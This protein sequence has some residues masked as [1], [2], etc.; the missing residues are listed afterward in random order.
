MECFFQWTKVLIYRCHPL[1][2]GRIFVLLKLPNRLLFLIN[3]VPVLEQSLVLCPTHLVSYLHIQ[4]SFLKLA[5]D[6]G[7]R[8]RILVD[9]VSLDES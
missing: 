7:E 6:V 1:L 5:H 2:H 9:V 8:L 3:Y 4:Y